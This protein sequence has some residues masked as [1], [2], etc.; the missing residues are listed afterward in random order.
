MWTTY[1]TPHGMPFALRRS[2]AGSHFAAS[3]SPER[4]PRTPSTM[5]NEDPIVSPSSSSRST[6]IHASS[7]SVRL[8]C[9][10]LRTFGRFGP[11]TAAWARSTSR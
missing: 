1:T 9:M 7:S 2:T 11:N 3:G 5:S 6:G 8:D 4:S 10:V